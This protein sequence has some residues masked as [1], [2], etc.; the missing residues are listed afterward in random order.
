M[1]VC[2]Y[3]VFL[4]MARYMCRMNTTVADNSNDFVFYNNSNDSCENDLLFWILLVY[5]PLALRLACIALVTHLFL[6]AINAI[7]KTRE[8]YP[9]RFYSIK[10]FFLMNLLMSMMITVFVTNVVALAEIIKILM[11]PNA[12]LPL[13]S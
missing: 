9:Q 1:Y 13:Y 8:R 6:Y 10:Y 7:L 5:L 3:S 2:I 11:N 4:Y 12:K